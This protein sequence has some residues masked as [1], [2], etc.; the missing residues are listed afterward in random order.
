V[1]RDAHVGPLVVC[2]IGGSLAEALAESTVAALAPLAEDEALAL[3]RSSPALAHGLHSR[4][5]AAAASV[6][7]ALGRLAAHRPDVVAIDINPLRVSD[8]TATALDALIVLGAIDEETP[9]ISG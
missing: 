4:D 9:W 7:V 6:L 2:G 3:V 8:G 5:Q 1:V